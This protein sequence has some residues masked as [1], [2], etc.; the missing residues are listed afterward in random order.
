VSVAE[1]FEELSGDLQSLAER[2]G[3]L[4]MEL[5]REGLAGGTDESALQ[6]TKREKMVNRAR[7]SV[8]KAASLLERAGDESHYG[9]KAEDFDS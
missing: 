9:D 4:A 6:A 1:R 5:L 2:L 7:S 3:D 8:M